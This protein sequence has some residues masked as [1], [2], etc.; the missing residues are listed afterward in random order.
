MDRQARSTLMFAAGTVVG[1]AVLLGAY[2]AYVDRD[3]PPAATSSAATSEPTASLPAET[4]QVAAAAPAAAPST[5]GSCPTQAAAT[6][7]GGGDGQFELARALAMQPLP[8]ASAFLAVAREALRQGRPRDAET[9][10]IAACHT[11]ER[12]DGAQST[13]LADVKS[14]LGQHYAGLARETQ[15]DGARD[16]LVQRASTLFSE[17]ASAYATALGRNA[18]KT[19]LA[20]Q[21]LAALGD[22]ALR[23]PSLRLPEAGA[24]AVGPEATAPDTARLG[25]ARTS[26][27]D[28]PP[29]STEDLDKVGGDLERLYEQARAVSRDPAGLQRRHQ[30]ALAQR[31]ACGGD[32]EC[33][34]QWAAQRKRQL[35]AE[36]SGRR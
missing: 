26:L 28:L 6:V 9:A 15:D 36:F 1:A 14:Q 31:S 8:D 4:A 18:S 2:F 13:P 30:Q 35:F 32:E 33:L 34:R 20:E 29:A 27:A 7:A 22:P 21:R 23:D 12:A 25:S 11:A 17:G 3:A 10:F 24:L 5:V 19:R 16:L